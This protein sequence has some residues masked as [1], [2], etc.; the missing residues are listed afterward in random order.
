MNTLRI[1]AESVARLSDGRVGRTGGPQKQQGARQAAA[2]RPAAAQRPGDEGRLAIVGLA[3]V[4]PGGPDPET[5]WQTLL[6]GRDCV[7]PAGSERELP[8]EVAGFLPGIKGFDARF[9]SI[10][11]REASWMD[12]RQRLL[13][14]SV[15]H[16]LEDAGYA[17]SELSG[18]RTGCYMAATGSDYALL[19]ARAGARQI[20]YSLV[21]HSMSLIANRISSWFDWRG[22]STVLD[23]ACSGSLVALVKACRDLRAGVCDAAV[24]GGVNLILD[25]QINEG[26]HSARFLSP[27]HRC[28]AFDAAANGYVRGEGYG[29]FLVK[30]LDDALADGD[31]IR[32]VVESVA[33]NHGGRA[34]SLT[35]PN[36]NAQYSL[37]LDAYTPELAARTGYIETHGTGTVLG[38]AI[39]IDALKRAWE[40]WCRGPR[41]AA[42]GS[43]RSSPTSGTW[44]PPRESP[45]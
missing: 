20:P 30:R 45:P 35:A 11:P 43:A 19:Q 1:V 15:W 2:P 32:A 29:S 42:F 6:D 24:V 37:L 33:E 13:L 39:E 41:G 14:Q 18:S 27:D 25:S 22:P 3:A 4:L 7:R 26:L 9:F 38:D 17:P 5:F 21:G 31:D 36:P 40:R 10:S 44:S 16:T 34:N 8:G 12:P 28:A 23:T